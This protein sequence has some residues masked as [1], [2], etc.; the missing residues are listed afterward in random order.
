[1]VHLQNG[2]EIRERGRTRSH[3][4]LYRRQERSESSTKKNDLLRRDLIQNR[5][6]RS[7]RFE[8]IELSGEG[9][10]GR[11]RFQEGVIVEYVDRW[12]ISFDDEEILW[13]S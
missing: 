7:D 11:S 13:C 3:V 12:E 10:D 5:N 2:D 6:Q 8:E 9:S 4:C 1:M